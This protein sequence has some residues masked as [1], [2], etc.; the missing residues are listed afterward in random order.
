MINF[1]FNIDIV[2]KNEFFR[3]TEGYPPQPVS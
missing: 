3:L 1:F 2:L